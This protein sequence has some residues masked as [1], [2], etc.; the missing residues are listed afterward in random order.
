MTPAY[1]VL[2]FDGTFTQPEWIAASFLQ[3]YRDRLCETTNLPLGTAWDRCLAFVRGCSPQLAWKRGGWEVCPAA[4][5]PYVVASTVAELV[6]EQAGQLEAW[7][8]LPFQLYSECYAAFPAPVRPEAT[9]VLRALLATGAKVCFVSNASNEKLN[10]RLSEELPAE[11]FAALKLVGDAGKFLIREAQQEG[12]LRGAFEELPDGKAMKALSR[13][14]LLRRGR[15]FDALQRLWGEDPEGPRRTLVCGDI[16]ELDLALP[17][18]LGCSVHLIERAEPF[19]S[20]AYERLGIEELGE[21][22]GKSPDLRG[23]LSRLS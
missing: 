20:F 16:W 5:D 13:P 17:E 23:L 10:K 7:P 14:S 18:A 11:V 15:Y 22:G 3:R 6:L 9:E 4:P 2:D 21:R 8:S 19:A 12:P 1:V